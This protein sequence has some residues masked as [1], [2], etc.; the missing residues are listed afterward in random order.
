MVAIVHNSGS[1]SNALPYNENKVKQGVAECIHSMSYPKDTG[2]LSFKDKSN[3]LEKLTMLNQQTTINSFHISL[4]FD[5]SEKLSSEKLKE[6]AEVY[7][8]KIGF[9]EQP[10]LVCQHYDTGHPHLHIVTASIRENGKLIKLHNL[11]QHRSM[12]AY[13]C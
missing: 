9:G 1:L 13:S 3:R 6:I 4:N 11:G 10:Y 2:W 12:N 8:Q 7:M 5:P